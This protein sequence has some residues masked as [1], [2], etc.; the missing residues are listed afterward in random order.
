MQPG[1][2]ALR[3]RG[4]K[5]GPYCLEGRTSDDPETMSVWPF[6]FELRIRFAL[7]G[8]ILRQS[9]GVRN[10]GPE[11]MYFSIGFHPG[12]RCPLREGEHFEDYA[13]RFERPETL[14]RHNLRDGLRTGKTIPFLDNSPE[15]PLHRE[16]FDEG[17]IVLRNPVSRH[18]D[19]W[20]PS[21]GHG[22][23]CGIGGFAWLGLWTRGAGP[24]LCIEPWNGITGRTGPACDLRD[25]EGILRLSPGGISEGAT[26]I[27]PLLPE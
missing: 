21:T 16:L 19:L 6:Q 2:A 3:H 13:V 26:E 10:C 25:K 7:E 8:P 17:A 18:V 1:Q 27:R 22:V 9:Y 20:N 5:Q 15:I 23:R 11:E 24:F 4:S 14:P 12:F